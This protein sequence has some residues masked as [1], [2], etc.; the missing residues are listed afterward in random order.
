MPTAVTLTVSGPAVAGQELIATLTPP[1]PLDDVAVALVRTEHYRKN[2]ERELVDGSSNTSTTEDAIDL[3]VD[4][5]PVP[6][7][8]E[9]EDTIEATI[10][11]GAVAGPREVRIPIPADAK[12]SSPDLIAWVLR[13]IRDGE[14]EAPVVVATTPANADPE[15]FDASGDGDDQLSVRFPGGVAAVAA[16]QRLVGTVVIEPRKSARLTDVRLSFFGN[17]HDDVGHFPARSIADL[18]LAGPLDL[19]SGVRQE[20]PFAIDIPADARPTCFTVYNAVYYWLSVKAARKMRKD[21]ETSVR[22]YVAAAA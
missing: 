5:A 17:H 7:T 15:R 2:G 4:L 10:A 16:G 8:N 20:L 22:V 13:V 14:G 1:T 18:Q 9:V 11:L 6:S 21:Y 19:E 3:L 12:P